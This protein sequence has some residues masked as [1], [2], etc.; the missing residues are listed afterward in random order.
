MY[1]RIYIGLNPQIRPLFFLDE[2]ISL[3]TGMNKKA[4]VAGALMWRENHGW[5]SFLWNWARRI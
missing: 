3:G 1:Y 4:P 2:K 5:R